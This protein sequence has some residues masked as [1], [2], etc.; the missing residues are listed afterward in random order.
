MSKI[1]IE[2]QLPTSANVKYTSTEN[3]QVS[4]TVLT[5]ST[6]RTT[7]DVSPN[8]TIS[9]TAS[10]RTKT[11]QYSPGHRTLQVLIGVNGFDLKWD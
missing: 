3:N 2:N 5:K 4:Q 7:K 1:D 11:E 9:I 8:T 10:G 6:S